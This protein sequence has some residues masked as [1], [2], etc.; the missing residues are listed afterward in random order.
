[1]EPRERPVELKSTTTR[2]ARAHG[3]IFITVGVDESGAPFEVFV[4]VG[5]GD[6]EEKANAET[7]ARLV[8]LWLRSGGDLE[9]LLRQLRGIVGERGA[10]HDGVYVGSIA[11]AI[12]TVLAGAGGAPVATQAQLQPVE[13][14]EP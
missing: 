3:H 2:V 14:G 13:A 7:I 9:A 11:D 8:T 5:K 1:M 6:A 4:T 12:V 10:Y